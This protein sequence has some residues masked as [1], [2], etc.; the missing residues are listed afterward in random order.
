MPPDR[1]RYESAMFWLAFGTAAAVIGLA[2]MT[3]GVTRST[4]GASLLAN[5]WFDGGLV[6]LVIGA[7]MLL[8]AL[9]LYLVHRR[10]PASSLAPGR[11]HSPSEN[12]M[13]EAVRGYYA[14]RRKLFEMWDR[15]ERNRQTKK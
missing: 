14:E 6:L 2:L 3:I 13:V 15:R 9:W 12:P 4:P 1:G 10:A 8:G 11:Q 7:L 5:A